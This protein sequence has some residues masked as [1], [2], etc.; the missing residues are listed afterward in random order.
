MI[1]D[2]AID[3]GLVGSGLFPVNVQVP[4]GPGRRSHS[5]SGLPLAEVL[6]QAQIVHVRIQAGKEEPL[7]VR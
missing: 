7:L 5:S 1:G 2:C 3:T 6:H 4:V